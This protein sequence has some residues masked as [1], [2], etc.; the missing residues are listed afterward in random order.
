MSN[1][2]CLYEVKFYE[3]GKRIIISNR[4]KEFLEFIWVWEE[5]IFVLVRGKDMEYI[6]N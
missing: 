2:L 5:F 6:E 3:R 4:L 1:D